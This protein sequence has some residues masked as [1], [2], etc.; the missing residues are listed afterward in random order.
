LISLARRLTTAWALAFL[1][2]GSA[3]SVRVCA[4]EAPA[5]SQNQ[6][7]SDQYVSPGRQLAHETREAA[8]EE[9]DEN[10]E[11]KQSAAVRWIGRHTGLNPQQSY[12]LCVLSNF[13][14]VAALIV[15]AWNKR[16]PAMFSSRTAGIQTAMLEARKASEEARRKLADIEARLSKIDVEINAMREEAAREAA[17]EE[18]RIKAAAEEEARNIVAGAQ[19]EIAAAARAAR[20]QLAAHAADLAVGLAEKQIRIDSGTD[21]TLVRNFA[22]K[23]A[24]TPDEIGKDGH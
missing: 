1:I 14:V 6:N 15:W 9:K 2:V 21:Q 20:R 12:W 24:V 7:K 17:A 5:Q 10:A 11:F 3:L 19:Q 4:Q 22:T 8:G 18:G 23:L 16:V 13:V